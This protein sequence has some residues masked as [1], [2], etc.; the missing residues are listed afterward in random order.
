MYQKECEKARL[1]SWRDLQTNID[2]I[3]DM[4]KFRKIVQ[5]S[6]QVTLGTLTKENGEQT[7]P[8][9]E[10]IEYLSQIH[11]SKATP[12]KPTQGKPDRIFKTAIDNWDDNIITEEKVLAA[13]KVFKVK[14][15]PGTDGIHQLI[16]Q[17]LP[18][19]TIVYITKLYKMCVLL[20][21][22]PTR[23]KECR[24][25]FIPKPGKDSSKSLKHGDQYRLQ[26]TC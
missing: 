22:T 2:N 5:G 6:E 21:Y 24:I 20:G 4:N 13:I 1:K 9:A 18:A 25:V 26:T 8:G 16:L 7:R 17:K 3:S 23:W 10:T 12:L 19:E 11:F 15:S 14:K